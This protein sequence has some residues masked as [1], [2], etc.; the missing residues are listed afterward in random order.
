M[1]LLS[2]RWWAGLGVIVAIAGIVLGLILS[3]GGSSTISNN[4]GNCNVQGSGNTVNC[5]STDTKTGP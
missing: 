3:S 2:K 4:N 5:P 1:K